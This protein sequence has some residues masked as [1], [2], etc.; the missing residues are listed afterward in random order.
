MKSFREQRLNYWNMYLKHF[1]PLSKENRER[2]PKTLHKSL[3]G[4]LST[5]VNWERKENVKNKQISK[6]H[7]TTIYNSWWWVTIDLFQLRTSCM[8]HM[9]EAGELGV[10]IIWL[11]QFW[12]AP[13]TSADHFLDHL[14]VRYKYQPREMVMFQAEKEGRG[15]WGLFQMVSKSLHESSNSKHTWKRWDTRH[16]K[17]SPFQRCFKWIHFVHH[18]NGS[19]YPLL[20]FEGIESSFQLLEKPISNDSI[21]VL[22]WT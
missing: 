2:K 15:W 12:I 14:P 4:R 8:V 5:W 3:E 20:V 10:S 22:Q 18:S 6:T 1:S 16:W 7:I 19:I 9:K 21:F 17:I 11:Q 13:A